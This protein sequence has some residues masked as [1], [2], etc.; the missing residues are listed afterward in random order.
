MSN[1]QNILED[2]I[3]TW[4]NEAKKIIDSKGDT[5]IVNGTIRK[6]D[7]IY[8]LAVLPCSIVD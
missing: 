8:Q 5:V 6:W 1:L 4:R 7:N 2:K 3:E